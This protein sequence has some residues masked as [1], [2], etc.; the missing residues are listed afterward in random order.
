MNINRLIKNEKNNALIKRKKLI[1]LLKSVGITRFKAEVFDI[2][3]QKIES[4][5]K[6]WG[7]L[8]AHKLMI[9]GRKTLTKKD[10]VI[11]KKEEIKNPNRGRA[12]GYNKIATAIL[13][14]KNA[15]AFF[16]IF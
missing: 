12:P 8:F 13:C 11:E 16:C 4:E 10:L 7:E 14:T 2:L 6:M 9:E 15:I 1:A 3:E 5:I